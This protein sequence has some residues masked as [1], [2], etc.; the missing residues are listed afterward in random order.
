MGNRWCWKNVTASFAACSLTLTVFSLSS[1][2][3]RLH[4]GSDIGAPRPWKTLEAGEGLTGAADPMLPKLIEF[5]SGDGNISGSALIL[6]SVIAHL[7]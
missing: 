2:L 5:G 6:G 3:H 1:P 4:S 7:E